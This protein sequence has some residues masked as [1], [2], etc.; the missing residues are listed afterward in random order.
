MVYIYVLKL[1]QQK[2]YIGKTTNPCFRIDRHFN[3]DG[4]QWTKVYKP[5]KLVEMIPNC[6]D[7]DEDKYTKIYMDKYGIENVRGGS[8]VSMKFD[9]GTKK[10]LIKS[11]KNTNNKCFNCGLTGHFAKECQNKIDSCTNTH[12]RCFQCGKI[13]HYSSSCYS[14]KKYTKAHKQCDICGKYGHYEVNCNYA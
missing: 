9:T 3:G 1:E 5:I 7:Y 4:A 12:I 10:E 13:G 11:S 2:Y 14:T 6:D 8:Y